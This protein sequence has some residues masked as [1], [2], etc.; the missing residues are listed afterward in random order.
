MSLSKGPVYFLF[1]R[2]MA[3]LVLSVLDHSYWWIVQFEDVGFVINEYT[4]FLHLAQVSKQLLD[5]FYIF[6]FIATTVITYL[7][8]V[9][10]R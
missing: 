3:I 9:Y 1:I 2:I 7:S 5:F 6:G 8:S 10:S 4:A